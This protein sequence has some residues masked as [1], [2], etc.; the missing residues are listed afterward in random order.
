MTTYALKGI[1][2]LIEQNEKQHQEIESLKDEIATLK[3]QVAFL[4]G[5]ENS[6]E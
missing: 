5:K 4:M 3:Q 2:E 6:N 1:Q